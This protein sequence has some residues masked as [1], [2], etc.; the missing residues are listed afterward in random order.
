V[1]SKELADN[2]IFFTNRVIILFIISF[3]A[4]QLISL[5]LIIEAP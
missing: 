3:L 5:E 4:K 2:T 1:E